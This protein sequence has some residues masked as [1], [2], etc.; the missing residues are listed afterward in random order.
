MTDFKNT[1][2]Y[3]LDLDAKDELR[4]FRDE[5]LFPQHEGKD[6]IYYTGN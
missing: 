1:H 3:A 6:A 2:Q 4:S 5:F